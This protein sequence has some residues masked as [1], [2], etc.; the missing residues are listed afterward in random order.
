MLWGVD[1]F[2]SLHIEMVTVQENEDCRS[3]KEAHFLISSR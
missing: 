2:L 1:V 3:A